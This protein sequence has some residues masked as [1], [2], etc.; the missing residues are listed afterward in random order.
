MTDGDAIGEFAF[1]LAMGLIGISVFFGPVGRA[2]GRWLEP[3]RT[4]AQPDPE[5]LGDIEHRL[6]EL[7]QSQHR[8]A[9]L[10]E[11]VDFAERMLAQH[12][13]PARLGDGG[14]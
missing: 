7:E 14:G 13:D 6:T 5:R 12:R 10:E 3:R 4:P 11:R 2:L 1:W 8:V 9:E